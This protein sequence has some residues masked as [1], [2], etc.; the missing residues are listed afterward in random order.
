MKII[1]FTKNLHKLQ[2]MI[3]IEAS[4]LDI[5]TALELNDGK[6]VLMYAAEL[7]CHAELAY[8]I[9]EGADVLAKDDSGKAALDFARESEDERCIAIL[10]DKLLG[11]TID[12]GS[13]ETSLGF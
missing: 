7:G 8:L 4:L 13:I 11:K 6:T 1:P 9:N 5:E 12:S 2:S 3:I 10:E